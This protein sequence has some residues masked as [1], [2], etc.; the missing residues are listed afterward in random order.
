MTIDLS[1]TDTIIGGRIRERRKELGM[2]AAM[3]G[4][5]TGLSCSFLSDLENGRRGVSAKN[6]FLI[7]E[8]L[9]VDVNFFFKPLK[10]SAS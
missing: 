3:L 7:A 8:S 5:L 2:T 9:Q 10:G 4:R 1:T 6:I